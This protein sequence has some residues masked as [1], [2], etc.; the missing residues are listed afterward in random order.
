MPRI[1]GAIKVSPFTPPF[2]RHQGVK[3]D[4]HPELTPDF[5]YTSSDMWSM[6]YSPSPPAITRD[7]HDWGARAADVW[8]ETSHKGQAWC[9]LEAAKR[10]KSDPIQVLTE[11]DSTMNRG[12]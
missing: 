4:I 11:D 12:V 5:P 9:D 7:V 8:L 10:W 2:P 3:M 1:A 6:C